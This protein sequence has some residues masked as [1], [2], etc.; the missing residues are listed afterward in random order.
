MKILV[1]GSIAYDYLMS[2][3]GN[4][5]EHFI[6]DKLD[7]IS[8]SF[9][10]DSMRKQR[11]GCGPNIAYSL[12]LL[13]EKPMLIGSAGE[14]FPEYR[15]WLEKSGVDVSG[16]WE[17]QGVFTASF[18]ANTDQKGNQICSF[19]TGAMQHA[20]RISL[21]PFLKNAGPDALVV[22][23]PND[24]QA[25]LKYPVECRAAGARFIFDPGQQ[26]V[27]LSGDELKTGAE[28]A[29]ILILNEYEYELFRN[30]TG[31]DEQAVLSLTENLIVTLGEKGASI[32]NRSGEIRIPVAPPGKVMDPTGVGD[33][34]R[35]GLVKGL[36]KGLSWETAGRMGTLAA[37]Y[38]LETPGPQSHS[39]DLDGFIKRF[40]S[41]F[42]ESGELAGLRK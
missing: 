41:V 10:V 11:G 23:S 8:V 3:P 26:V 32:R 17:I 5:S 35:A 24:P 28:K 13:G 37:T 18:F 2:F 14:D 22:V 33:A 9:L 30:K 42:G 36:A 39:Y 40:V 4:F 29:F 20:R 25:M 27:R 34:F 31:L 12:A 7:T 16:V 6:P 38:V 15:A 21:A 1:T 19:Y